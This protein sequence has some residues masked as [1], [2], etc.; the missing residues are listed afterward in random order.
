MS[1]DAEII[2][3]RLAQDLRSGQF[4]AGSWLKQVDLQARYGVGR[5]PVRKALE[6]LAGRRLIRYEKNRGYSVHPTDDDDTK[7]VLAIRVA[8]ET[9][10]SEALCLGAS[11]EQITELQR[12]AEQF[13]QIVQ[14]GPFDQLYETNL[15]F[16]RTLLRCSGN[17]PMVNLVDD[18]RLR[19]SPAPASQWLNRARIERSAAEHIKMVD[20]LRVKDSAE[21]A[22]LIRRHI[23]Q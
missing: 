4:T 20:A 18:L 12:L 5:A 1:D 2:A 23:L 7:Q 8:I 6:T 16:H 13:S 17:E 15:A 21:L 14:S 22:K 19:T 9:G 3:D 11:A 10:F